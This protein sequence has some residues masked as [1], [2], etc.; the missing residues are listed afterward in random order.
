MSMQIYSEQTQHTSNNSEL[1]LEENKVYQL[2]ENYR[3]ICNMDQLEAIIENLVINRGYLMDSS[4][5]KIIKLTNP[6]E[7]DTVYYV[8]LGE[9]L[10]ITKQVN[11]LVGD[12]Y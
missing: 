1:Y 10:G 8:F 6:Q 4:K 7:S 3:D 2:I 12:V 9:N 5:D 11:R